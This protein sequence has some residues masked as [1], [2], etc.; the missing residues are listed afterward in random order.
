MSPS[1]PRSSESVE[2]QERSPRRERRLL[3]ELSGVVPLG[4]YAAV[5]VGTYARALFGREH[6]GAADPR[7][8]LQV[9]LELVLVWVP[10]AFHGGYGL[11]LSLRRVHGD[12]GERRTTLIL[13]GT[14]VLAFAF[15]VAH[16]LWLRLPLWRGERAPE[17]TLQMLAAGLSSTLNGVPVAAAVHVLGILALAAHLGYGLD[18]FLVDY[19]V[20]APRNARLTSSLLS[21]T[22]FLVATATIV[23]LATGSALPVFVR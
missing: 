4:V 22:L 6:F 23:E 10:L 3:F 15:I 7:S 5:H 1:E 17:D 21:T 18:R 14:G 2:D 8:W 12:S 20:L 16:T 13:R 11:A 9:G 19:G